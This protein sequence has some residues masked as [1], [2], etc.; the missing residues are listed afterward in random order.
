MVQLTTGYDPK[1]LA[2]KVIIVDNL[3]VTRL[4]YDVAQIAASPIQKFDVDGNG[5]G[6]GDDVDVKLTDFNF[7]S[8]INDDYGSLFLTFR[9]DANELVDI[10]K[11]FP[12]R[13]NREWEVQFSLGKDSGSINRYFY[14][15]IKDATIVRPGTGS[16]EIQLTC[17]GWGIILRERITRLIRNQKKLANG[18]DLDDTDTDARID[19]LI[20]DLF[21]DTDHYVDDNIT[22]LGNFTVASK[23][24]GTGICSDCLSTKLANIN[25][26]LSTFAQVIS[27]L[28]GISN[29]VWL[30]SDPDRRIIIHDPHAHDSGFMFTNDLAAS[31]T[32]N[33]T[34]N[35]LS[36]ITKRPLAWRDSSNDTMFGFIHA[37]G[38]FNPVLDVKFEDTADA[39]DNL[40]DEWKA[41]G[42]TPT[43]NTVFKIAVKAVKTG[44]PTDDGSVE[45][46]GSDGSNEPNSNNVL[47]TIHLSKT[48]L[49][50][51]G[52]SVPADWFEI[53]IRPRLD[54]VPDEKYFIVFKKNGTVAN[55]WNINYEAGD[56]TDLFYFSPD[57]A[58][59]NWT[60]TTA[61]AG[62]T[63]NFR[64]YEGKRLI[65]TLE[66]SETI[67]KLPEVRERMFPTRA[68]S[69]E[70]SIRETLL[71]AAS[72]L[73]QQRRTYNDLTVTC[74][75]DRVLPGFFCRVDDK[76]T[77][78][79]VRPLI[80]TVSIEGHIDGDR[81]GANFMILGLEDHILT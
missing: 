68:D 38:H 31:D 58:Q 4:Q 9:D 74:P 53:P 25:T 24:D 47:R 12:C 27:D 32:I 19:E 15:K 60:R 66:I 16:E 76:I 28:T 49:Q 75:T 2:P 36:Y 80:T 3:G 18:I 33:W 17:V 11:G 21:N 6:G 10:T 5:I 45:I 29:A 23:T 1:P 30:A 65:T 52:T 67:K 37:A 73:G 71:N 57:G 43:K 22:Q 55:T 8:G 64:V 13:I 40:D 42:F 44:T 20:K 81:L 62:G 26:T 51:L 14:G 78:L 34:A 69:E 39:S 61:G 59:G 79:S 48:K 77:G 72:L 70:Q 54:V 56:S 50:G 41:Q 7:R 35:K 63:F 46:W